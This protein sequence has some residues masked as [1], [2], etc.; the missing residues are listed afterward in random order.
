MLKPSLKKTGKSLKMPLLFLILFNL[1][2][3]IMITCLFSGRL[4][5]SLIIS[6]YIRMEIF[7]NCYSY[8]IFRIY[9]ITFLGNNCSFRSRFYKKAQRSWF[10][11]KYLYS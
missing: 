6:F 3:A 9:H 2:F 7:V 8:Y 1:I 11:S 10:F 4:F 5:I